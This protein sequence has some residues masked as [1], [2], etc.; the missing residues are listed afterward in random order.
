MTSIIY[1][2]MAVCIVAPFIAFLGLLY[3]KRNRVLWWIALF[4]VGLMSFLVLGLITHA[5]SWS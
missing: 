2:I 1:L 3:S 4:V 5:V